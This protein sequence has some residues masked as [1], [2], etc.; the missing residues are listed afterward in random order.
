MVLGEITDWT[1]VYIMPDDGMEA[2]AL[3]QPWWQPTKT[4]RIRE[5]G[6]V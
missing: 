2:G 6:T 4:I 5:V 3:Q 1:W